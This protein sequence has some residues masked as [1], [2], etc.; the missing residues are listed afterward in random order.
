MPLES[1]GSPVSII[2]TDMNFLGWFVAGDL[3]LKKI[4][5]DAKLT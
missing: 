1:T 3:P 5:M 2:Y 4:N